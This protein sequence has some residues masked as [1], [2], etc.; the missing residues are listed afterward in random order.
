MFM[1]TELPTKHESLKVTYESSYSTVVCF[2]HVF[3][4]IKENENKQRTE[5]PGYQ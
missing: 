4:N 5:N 1:T 2:D 3:T